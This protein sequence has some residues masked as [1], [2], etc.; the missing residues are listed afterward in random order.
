MKLSHRIASGILFLFVVSC[1]DGARPR[2]V[3]P[4]GRCGLVS[5]EYADTNFGIVFGPRITRGDTFQVDIQA[6]SASRSDFVGTSRGGIWAEWHFLNEDGLDSTT[7]W[8]QIVLPGTYT[9][10]LHLVGDSILWR[11]DDRRVPWMPYAGWRPQDRRLVADWSGPGWA[12][13]SAFQC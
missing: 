11:F 3:I 7:Y 6:L 9:G 5:F 1:Q 4:E 8:E 10:T 12:F 13:R 2:Y